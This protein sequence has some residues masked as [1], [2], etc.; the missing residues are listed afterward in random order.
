MPKNQ[1]INAKKP[2]QNHDG[3]EKTL[4]SQKPLLKIELQVDQ[5]FG[6]IETPL[7][8]HRRSAIERRILFD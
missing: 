7:L 3:A 4:W 2:S 5:I 1:N 6:R 8:C